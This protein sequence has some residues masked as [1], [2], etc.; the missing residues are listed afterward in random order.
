MMRPLIIGSGGTPAKIVSKYPDDFRRMSQCILLDTSIGDIDT[1]K[2]GRWD[3]L[4]GSNPGYILMLEELED[5]KEKDF[6][7]LTGEALSKCQSGN[8]RRKELLVLGFAYDENGSGLNIANNAWKKIKSKIVFKEGEIKEI[9]YFLH[10]AGLAGGTGSGT[11]NGLVTKIN[12]DIKAKPLP[13]V[14]LGILPSREKSK[15]EPNQGDNPDRAIESK[16]GDYFIRQEF[17]ALWA[18]YDLML[19]K[20]NL[21]LI[22]NTVLPSEND[23]FPKKTIKD[24][25][26]MLTEWSFSYDAGN[27]F[28]NICKNRTMAPYYASIENISNMGKI[29]IDDIDNMLLNFAIDEG[30]TNSHKDSRGNWLLKVEK[31]DLDKV[32]KSEG[33]KV[34]LITKGIVKNEFIERVKNNISEIFK[35]K[36]KDISSVP[37]MLNR[38]GKAEILALAF[39]E[40]PLAIKRIKTLASNVKAN[41]GELLA[42]YFNGYTDDHNAKGTLV[43]F[44]E[45]MI[46]S[47][48][49]AEAAEAL[50][51]CRISF[52]SGKFKCSPFAGA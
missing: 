37:A 32:Q 16:H 38:P 49:N 11:I 22:D 9:D 17:N 6:R 41:K 27:L 7:N 15:D 28:S 34:F 29:K 45:K 47:M 36:E 39:F 24:V 14:V 5:S 51:Q 26:N 3:S 10:I 40:S 42:M 30:A 20:K 46:A 1:R 18:L 8:Y 2:I 19:P 25:I 33:T 52:E 44:A 12:E 31:E 23:S 50:E 35:I 21:I 4:R 48:N 13:H 43:Q